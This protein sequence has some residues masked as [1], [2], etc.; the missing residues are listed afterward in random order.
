MN[1]DTDEKTKVYSTT[2]NIQNTSRPSSAS[3]TTTS[4][5]KTSDRPTS[6]P[7]TPHTTSPNKVPK[8]A[9][10]NNYIKQ[11]MLYKAQEKDFGALDI[12]QQPSPSL[13]SIHKNRPTDATTLT[14]RNE[15]DEEG[16]NYDPSEMAEEEEDDEGYLSDDVRHYYRH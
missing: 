11:Y 13:P 2:S 3:A 5:P 15:E 4:R 14:N 8:N 9:H 6:T 1:N 7:H 10:S 12:L 16:Q